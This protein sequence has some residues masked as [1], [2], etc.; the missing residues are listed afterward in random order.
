M[1]RLAL[2]TLLICLLPAVAHAGTLRAGVGRA[3]VTPPTG[4]YMMGWVDSRA[5][6][7]GVWTRLFARALVLERD[8]RKVALVAMDANAV[9]GGLVAQVAKNLAKRGFTE[10]NILATAS[11]THAQATGW[12]PFTTYNTVFMSSSTPADQNVAGPPAPQLSAFM[13]RQGGRAITRADSDLRPAQAGWGRTALLGLTA[14][15]SL[16]AHLA[17]FGFD[18]PRGQG[19]VAMDPHGSPGTIYPNVKLVRVDQTVRGRHV[20]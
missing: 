18:I 5:K 6:P 7:E 15:R 3:D 19:T 20:P 11:H 1:R 16:E 2:V 12:Y 8:G 4:Y 13:V 9:P 14:N 17:N 10:R